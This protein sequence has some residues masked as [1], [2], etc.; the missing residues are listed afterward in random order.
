MSSDYERGYNDGQAAQ[1]YEELERFDKMNHQIMQL[2]AKLRPEKGIGS[3]T[4]TRAEVGELLLAI[5]LSRAVLSENGYRPHHGVEKR[6][7]LLAKLEG[8]LTTL[9]AQRIY[10]PHAEPSPLTEGQRAELV[11]MGVIL[12]GGED[13]EDDED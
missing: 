2:E 4:L 6:L 7:T 10:Y 8:E 5:R 12:M 9:Q 11:R 13:K 3:L 1:M